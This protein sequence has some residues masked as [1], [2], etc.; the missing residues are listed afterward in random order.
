MME[1]IPTIQ[2]VGNNS[3]T[4]VPV[5]ARRRYR[6]F[7]TSAPITSRLMPLTAAVRI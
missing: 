5:D 3:N 7:A 2:D 4:Q 6:L 1:T